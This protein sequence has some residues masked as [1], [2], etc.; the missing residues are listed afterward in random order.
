MANKSTFLKNSPKSIFS[1][2]SIPDTYQSMEGLTSTKAYAAN[3]DGAILAGS[4]TSIPVI[5]TPTTTTTTTTT[6]TSTTTTTTTTP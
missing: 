3:N 1:G 5:P 4:S 6:T 2:Q